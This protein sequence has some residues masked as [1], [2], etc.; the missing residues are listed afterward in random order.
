MKLKNSNKSSGK[1]Q[2]KDNIWTKK[3][4]L[5]K[6]VQLSSSVKRYHPFCFL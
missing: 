5:G 2:E 1:F 6:K 3:D 4:F